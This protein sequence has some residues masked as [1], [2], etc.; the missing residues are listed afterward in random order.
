MGANKALAPIIEGEFNIT[1]RPGSILDTP[2]AKALAVK[3]M[4]Q[5][6]GRTAGGYRRQKDG[7][8]LT[9]NCKRSVDPDTGQQVFMVPLGKFKR[10]D[11]LLNDALQKVNEAIGQGLN[12]LSHIHI[13][14]DG[15]VCL[16]APHYQVMVGF[17]GW[18]YP[19]HS[20][21]TLEM[22]DDERARYGLSKDADAGAV[23]YILGDAQARAGYLEM[24]KF[25]VRDMG[26]PRDEA[27]RAAL[28][29]NATARGI[30]VCGAGEHE[31]TRAVKA[32]GGAGGFRADKRS[33]SAAIYNL[34]GKM[35]PGQLK[36]YNE[37]SSGAILDRD[38]LK[39]LAEY[40][41]VERLAEPE[42][43][44]VMRLN[45]ENK[46]TQARWNAMT[47][48]ERQASAAEGLDLRPR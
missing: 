34:I 31:K 13:W 24:M 28:E 15:G 37:Q 11:L 30:G 21:Q 16:M 40:P 10:G 47:P 26:M 7:E 6:R 42:Q 29:D 44:R 41:N 32:R 2:T 27:Q 43:A 5:W 45:A 38:S 4:L 8:Q 18:A 35:P 22:A 48:E 46:A 1:E 20:M 33:V 39:A 12:P 9:E 23:T 19:K 14:Y 3:L 17:L 36:Q 25:Y